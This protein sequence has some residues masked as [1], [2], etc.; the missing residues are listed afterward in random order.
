MHNSNSQSAS[1]FY[2]TMRSAFASSLQSRESNAAAA[3]AP[4][5]TRSGFYGSN[6][7]SDANRRLQ[8]LG[9]ASSPATGQRLRPGGGHDTSFPNEAAPSAAKVIQ[10][11][12][13]QRFL[14]QQASTWVPEAPPQLPPV[15]DSSGA[16][17]DEVLTA[18]ELRCLRVVELAWPVSVAY[19]EQ[20]T[21]DASPTSLRQLA[22]EATIKIYPRHVF[23]CRAANGAPVAEIVIAELSELSEDEEKGSL[24]FFLKKS[25]GDGGFTVVEITCAD[26]LSRSAI[27]KL[28]CNRRSTIENETQ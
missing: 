9:L 28:V 16:M 7:T 6:V 20:R 26:A 13:D 1:S 19:G 14:P 22:E 3:V 10:P 11:S 24:S 5:D 18:E 27:Y 23:L 25:G 21:S 2:Q 17:D 15:G 4:S 12:S 8:S